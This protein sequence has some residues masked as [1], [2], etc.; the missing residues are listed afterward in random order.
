MAARRV[1]RPPLPSQSDIA[2]LLVSYQIPGFTLIGH[3]AQTQ[4]EGA[5]CGFESHSVL[6]G[7]VFVHE[8]VRRGSACVCVRVR[9]SIY[10]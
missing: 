3:G 7:G 6:V 4:S 10:L 5:T 9:A 1:T 2:S 8:H